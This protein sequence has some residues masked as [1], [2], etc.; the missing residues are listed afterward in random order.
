M[1]RTRRF[2]H[3]P[4][5]QLDAEHNDESIEDD[6]SIRRITHLSVSV[7][8]EDEGGVVLAASY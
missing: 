1:T 6:V 7:V 3:G 2:A 4:G 8:R 5:R